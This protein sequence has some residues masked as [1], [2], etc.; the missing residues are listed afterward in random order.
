MHINHFFTPENK[1]R[2]SGK[3]P[4]GWIS[5]WGI[6]IRGTVIRGNIL[7]GNCSL[8]ELTFGELSLGN[9]WSGKSP[10]GKCPPGNCPNTN[11]ML[12]L[13]PVRKLKPCLYKECDQLSGNWKNGS[14]LI[15]NNIWRLGQ[16]KKD[17]CLSS[18]SV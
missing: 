11:F 5:L 16:V 18:M 2:D 13:F 3:Y 12:I 15:L 17:I 9:C 1:I 7:S 14:V 10:L 8:G 4:F 6:V